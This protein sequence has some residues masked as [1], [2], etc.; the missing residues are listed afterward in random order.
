MPAIVLLPAKM[1]GDLRV[2][3]EYLVK[4]PGENH[5]GGLK[6]TG[7]WLEDPTLEMVC[8]VC[9]DIMSLYA[10]IRSNQL[11]RAMNSLLQNNQGQTLLP[12]SVS[13]AMRNQLCT[14]HFILLADP[15][16]EFLCIIL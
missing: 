13:V 12:V 10:Q 7:R 8:I 9:V 1:V 14:H 16:E 6:H 5:T 2:I 11:G 15:Q 4:A 3:A